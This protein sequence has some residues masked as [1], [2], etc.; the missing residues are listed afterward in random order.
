MAH[1]LSPEMHNAALKACGIEAQYVRL[2]LK[3]E[4][5]QGGGFSIKNSPEDERSLGFNSGSSSG[6]VPV[7][8]GT[9]HKV[10]VTAPGE[11]SFTISPG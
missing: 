5:F 1:S 11:W 7:E 8:P 10:T 2:H 9:Y 4:E 6:E 3:P